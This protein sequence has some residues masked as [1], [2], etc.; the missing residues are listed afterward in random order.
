MLR[1]FLSAVVEDCIVFLPTTSIAT[2]ISV[3]KQVRGVEFLFDL[4]DQLYA[5]CVFSNVTKLFAYASKIVEIEIGSG[6]QT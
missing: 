1:E 5:H 2:M 3:N 4:F 6:N